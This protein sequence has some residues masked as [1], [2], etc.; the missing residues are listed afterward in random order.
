MK[1]AAADFNKFV[2][3]YYFRCDMIY[4]WLH[5]LYIFIDSRL[6]CKKVDTNYTIARV[7]RVSILDCEGFRYMSNSRYSYYM[8]F[9]RYELLF[10]TKLYK[11]TIKNGLLAIL[12]SQKIIYKKP[13]KRWNKFTIAL[14]LEGVEEQWAYHKAVFTQNKEV[15]AIGYTKLAFR[16]NKKAQN[17]EDILHNCGHEGVIK[18][19]SNEVL[20]LFNIDYELLHSP[21]ITN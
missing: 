19:P 10:R 7:R 12:G 6:F 18:R 3:T 20:N 17:M 16:K 4:Y 8:D 11:Y 5:V 14:Y 9:S 13:L 1:A 15:C 21:T 2:I